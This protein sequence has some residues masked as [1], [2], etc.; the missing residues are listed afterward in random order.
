MVPEMQVQN[1]YIEFAPIDG[2]KVTTS[3]ASGE[4]PLLTIMRSQVSELSLNLGRG[5]FEDPEVLTVESQIEWRK[6]LD[7]PESNSEDLVLY[8]VGQS[9]TV[10]LAGQSIPMDFPLATNEHDPEGAFEVYSDRFERNGKLRVERC[11][12]SWG[13]HTQF[14]DFPLERL[15]DNQDHC[16]ATA[17]LV[18]IDK[19]TG[20]IIAMDDFSYKFPEDEQ[21]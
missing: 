12:G 5:E 15:Q 8:T 10:P 19:L 14:V 17:I 16:T 20:N 18:D 7:W 3:D 11:G 2:I 6:N 1:P 4:T 9:G 13:I 21:P